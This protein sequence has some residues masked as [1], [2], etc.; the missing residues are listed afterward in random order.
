MYLYMS[1]LSKSCLLFAIYVNSAS[2]APQPFLLISQTI[3][4]I[5]CDSDEFYPF[6]KTLKSLPS[7]TIYNNWA[8]TVFTN[9]LLSL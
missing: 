2:M 7:K 4:E 6:S 3:F 5:M 9:T 8:Y 1:R